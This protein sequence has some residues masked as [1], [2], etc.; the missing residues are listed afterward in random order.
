MRLEAFSARLM[1]CIT[2]FGMMRNVHG[3]PGSVTLI[4]EEP[5]LSSGTF[6]CSTIGHHGKRRVRAFLAD[7]DVGLELLD[8]ALGGLRCGKRAA[9]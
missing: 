5:A 3:L 9:A 4:D 1:P 7:D 8:Q 2:S 6:A